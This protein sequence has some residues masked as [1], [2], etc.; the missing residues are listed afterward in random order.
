MIYDPN[1]L[2][3][4]RIMTERKCTL[5]FF[6][7]FFLKKTQSRCWFWM[8]ISNFFKHFMAH[9]WHSHRKISSPKN[10]FYMHTTVFT[11]WNKLGCRLTNLHLE[12][13]RI[14]S[15]TLIHN[16][17]NENKGTN[18]QTS[19]SGAHIVITVN[20]LMLSDFLLLLVC[21]SLIPRKSK[22]CAIA[23]ESFF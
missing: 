19:L 9:I 17:Y 12:N 20:W 23:F 8:W 15:P 14:F 1:R 4:S 18:V 21:V 7:S 22:Q 3:C 10:T 13:G 5:N 11:V 2:M 16:F 6:F